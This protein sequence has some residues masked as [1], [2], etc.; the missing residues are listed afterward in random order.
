MPRNSGINTSI[1]L[2]ARKSFSSCAKKA[3]SEGPTISQQV[4]PSAQML[5]DPHMQG[6]DPHME[7]SGPSNSFLVLRD[8]SVWSD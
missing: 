4:F 7:G 5:L 2:F 8:Q 3:F 1:A 6:L